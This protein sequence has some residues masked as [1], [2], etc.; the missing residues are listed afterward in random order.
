[1]LTLNPFDLPGTWYKGNLHCHTTES[2]G[3]LSPAEVSDWYLQ[4]GYSFI[5]I[6]DHNRVTTLNGHQ[7][8]L[9]TIPGVEIS[10][11][12]GLQEYH[13]I[14]IDVKEMPIKPFHN[15][16]EAI[17]AIN[18]CGG[19]SIIAHPYWHDLQLEDLL[20][21]RGHLGIEIFNTS[22]WIDINKGHSLAHWDALLRRGPSL[23]GFASDDAHFK[24]P[25]YGG[26][27]IMVKATE[28]EPASIIQAIKLGNFYSS[29]GPEIY[30]MS[31][32]NNHLH[33]TCS[34]VRSIYVLGQYYFSPHS[35]NVWDGYR[36]NLDTSR[37]L[38]PESTDKVLTEATIKLDS[39]QE[40]LRVEI[41]D[42]YGR[43]AWSN[44]YF[45]NTG[46]VHWD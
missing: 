16:Q 39:R 26:G 29:M 28:L 12:Q 15:P 40:I 8:K 13:V 20:S 1:M 33:I 5:S 36:G 35:I 10:C 17:N 6:T 14:G 4:H 45:K 32:E 38:M 22:C 41:V 31:I 3:A 25:D 42:F 46:Q 21:L 44:P 7:T 2:D 37:L 9:V 18:A 23:W 11:R 19:S 27:W 30:H 24:I 43:S 34:P